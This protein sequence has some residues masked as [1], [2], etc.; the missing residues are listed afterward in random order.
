MFTFLNWPPRKDHLVTAWS[1]PSAP[2][3]KEMTYFTLVFLTGD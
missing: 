2:P 3:W 1:Q